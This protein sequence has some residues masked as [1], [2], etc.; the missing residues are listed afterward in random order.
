M[1][2]YENPVVCNDQ[3]PAY[4]NYSRQRSIIHGVEYRA[5]FTEVKTHYFCQVLFMAG[6]RI[7]LG[8]NKSINR[9]RKP[10]SSKR[11]VGVS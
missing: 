5:I 3:T 10:L 9:I 2:S 7:L 4:K 6:L 1:L 8:K 11:G